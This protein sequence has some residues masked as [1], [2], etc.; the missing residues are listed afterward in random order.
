MSLGEE[1]LARFLERLASDEAAP[2]GGAAAAVA[3][4][5]SASLVAMAARLSAGDLDDAA[6][7]AAAADEIRRQALTL[8]DADVAA[9]RRVLAGYRLPRDADPE[10]RRREIRDALQA[11]T[12]VPLEVARLAAEG[13]VMGSRLVDTGNPNLEGDATAAVLLARAAAQAAARLVELNVK[14]GQLGGDW[15]AQ[16]A[17]HV[18][19]AA[20]DAPPTG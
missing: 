18:A 13:A 15:C 5:L 10:G 19:R 2:G 17:A 7:I 8:A 6:A 3:T 20:G 11:A 16:A 1:P 14:Q 4:S 9:Y 12:A